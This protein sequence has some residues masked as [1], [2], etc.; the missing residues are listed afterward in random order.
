[1]LYNRHQ[2][3]SCPCPCQ[4][5]SNIIDIRLSL[6]LLGSLL[7]CPALCIFSILESKMPITSPLPRMLFQYL[8][9]FI[10]LPCMG[11]IRARINLQTR[12]NI[13]VPEIISSEHSEYSLFENFFWFP[14]QHFLRPALFQTTRES[15]VPS[16]QFILPLVS[17]EIDL[18]KL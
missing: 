6:D 4:C 7:I 1:M 11:M 8:G 9:P 5:P 16:V 18:C 2:W 13:F 12:F 15:S 17:S 14:F 3:C 10:Y